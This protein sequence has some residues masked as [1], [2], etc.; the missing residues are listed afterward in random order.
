MDTITGKALAGME[1]EMD[2]LTVLSNISTGMDL[3]RC[4]KKQEQPAIRI[5]SSLSGSGN[6]PPILC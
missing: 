1:I 4:R 2:T 3:C 6:S 5:K